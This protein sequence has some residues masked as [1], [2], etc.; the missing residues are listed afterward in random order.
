MCKP[1]V[2]TCCNDGGDRL[3]SEIHEFIDDYEWEGKSMVEVRRTW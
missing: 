3:W 1:T 2:I